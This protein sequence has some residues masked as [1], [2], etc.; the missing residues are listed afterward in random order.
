[1]KILIVIAGVLVAGVAQAG[2][3]GGVCSLKRD[4]VNTVET[5]SAEYV[6]SP[7]VNVIP[8]VIPTVSPTV[9]P[10]VIKEFSSD[11]T[12]KQISNCCSSAV[13]KSSARTCRCRCRCR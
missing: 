9:S 6:V 5:Y 13:V 12:V 4:K 10:T 11:N 1:M 3:P 8:T 2:C 7:V